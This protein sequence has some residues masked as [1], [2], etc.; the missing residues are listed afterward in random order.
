MAR[1][2]GF[3]DYDQIA[4]RYE[5][6]RALPFDV[7]DR[8]HAAIRPFLPAPLSRLIDVGAGTGVFARAWPSWTRAHVVAIEPSAAMIRVGTGVDR[9]FS[10]VMGSAEALSL[11]DGCIDLAWVS[12]ALHHFADVHRAIEELRR[13]LR[14]GGR[15]LIR[16][17]AP[18]RSEI[19]WAQEFPGRKRWEARFP[20]SGELVTW[21]ARHDFSSLA[22][23]DVLEGTESYGASARWASRMRHADS[24]LTALTEAEIAEG[25]ARLRA[26]PARE[27]RLTMTRLVFEKRPPA[28]D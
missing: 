15:I 16:T 13:V 11:G 22:V 6:G 8:W 4:S 12:T 7:L 21:F 18:D 17:Y 25:L 23:H 1:S 2:R 9:T 3:V 26:D 14:S 20:E 5:K 27:G 24:M 19:A 28:G 10:Y